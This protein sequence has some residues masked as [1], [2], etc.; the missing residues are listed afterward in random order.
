[1]KKLIFFFFLLSCQAC[2]P[3]L[4][5]VKQSIECAVPSDISDEAK[6]LFADRIKDEGFAEEIFKYIDKKFKMSVQ[7][8][9]I[10]KTIVFR[11]KPAVWTVTSKRLLVH[12]LTHVEQNLSAGCVEFNI[13][14]GLSWAYSRFKGLDE[15]D[16]YNGLIQE[17]EARKAEDNFL[18]CYQEEN[19][20]L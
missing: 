18:R 5:D 7:A 10:C 4:D 11:K 12:E 17:E 14:Y 8:I 19:L 2:D 1:M 3:I 15:Y 6:I 16:A 20:L 13:D 9:T